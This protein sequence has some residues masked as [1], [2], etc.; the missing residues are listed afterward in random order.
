MIENLSKRS[1]LEID[2]AKAN[3]N[4]KDI[5]DQLNRLQADIPAENKPIRI[6]C[7]VELAKS[8]IQLEKVDQAI[9]FASE[10]VSLGNKQARF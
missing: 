6:M 9:E 4:P 2:L 10:A 5:M 7:L 1:Q 3:S 8:A